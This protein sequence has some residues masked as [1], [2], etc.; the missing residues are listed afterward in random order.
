MHLCLSRPAWSCC[1]KRFVHLLLCWRTQCVCVCLRVCLRVCTCRYIGN[2]V[3]LLPLSD[4]RLP[5]MRER[6]V[7]LFTLNAEVVVEPHSSVRWVRVASVACGDFEYLRTNIPKNAA[8]PL[9]LTSPSLY[10]HC[11]V[12]NQGQWRPLPVFALLVFMVSHPHVASWSLFM[13]D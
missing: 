11:L 2:A 10:K 13:I 8:P 6:M 7:L 1:S 12:V 3:K 4:T 5:A 9:C